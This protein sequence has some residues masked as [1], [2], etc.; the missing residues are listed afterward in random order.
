MV[1]LGL[2]GL[3]G[4]LSSCRCEAKPEPVSQ[5]LDNPELS[6]L[7]PLSNAPAEA[8]TCSQMALPEQ[9]LRAT[10]LHDAAASSIEVE[11]GVL[12]K[13]GYALFSYRS[14]QETQWLVAVGTDR[15]TLVEIPLGRAIGMVDAPVGIIHNGA[16]LILLQHN[17]AMGQ[18]MQLVRI[19]SPFHEPKVT[20]GPS[21]S[22]GRDESPFASLAVASG[23]MGLLVWD[24]FDRAADRSRVMGLG[25]DPM[26]LKELN[27]PRILSLTDEDAEQ[28]K[29][30]PQ[31]EG[32]SLNY[33]HLTIEP[34]AANDEALVVEPKRSLQSRL[35][36][37]L[38]RPSSESTRVSEEFEH[39]LAFDAAE[40][41]SGWLL[42]Y[43]ST[44]AGNTVESSGISLAQVRLDG[45][46]IRGRAEHAQL[47]P[48]APVLLGHPSK[49]PWLLARGSDAE[50]LKAEVSDVADVR[51]HAES[52]LVE[53]IPMARFEE[54]LLAIKPV[55]LDW[56]VVHFDC[57]ERA[58]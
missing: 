7:E 21:V 35:L 29:L 55:G 15:D 36:D 49:N 25:F 28:P 2:V 45:T 52:A 8:E 22:I 19:D 1:G 31:G 4:L 18:K 26:T 5:P 16:L 37:G 50:L 56:S 33:L 27:A 53:T 54:R 10:S 39:V 17:E 3:A 41:R 13:S 51:L 48:G 34:A 58:R 30:L 23:G 9:L 38:G 6:L 47:G 42:A 14:N 11:S 46:V 24:E 40:I 44:R 12:S 20:R 43:R 57:S 32:F